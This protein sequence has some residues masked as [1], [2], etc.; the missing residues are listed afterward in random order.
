MCYKT[1][2]NWTTMF[3][4]WAMSKNFVQTVIGPGTKHWIFFSPELIHNLI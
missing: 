3:V 4:R 2:G 1:R